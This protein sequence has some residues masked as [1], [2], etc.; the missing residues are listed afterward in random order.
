MNVPQLPQRRLG[1][2][3][4]AI[5]LPVLAL[6]SAVAVN[7]GDSPARISA[8]DLSNVTVHWHGNTPR[9]HVAE[10]GGNS[11]DTATSDEMLIADRPTTGEQVAL[12]INIARADGAAAPRAEVQQNYEEAGRWLHAVSRGQ[13]TVKVEMFPRDVV[14][15]SLP[16]G[17]TDAVNGARECEKFQTVADV[18]WR[19][20]QQEVDTSRLRFVSYVMPCDIVAGGWGQVRGSLTWNWA[21]FSK[22]G[23]LAP[24]EY[25]V[26][27]EL[28]HNLGLWHA[29]TLKCTQDGVPVSFVTPVKDRCAHLEY[30][31]EWSFMGRAW[32]PVMSTIERRQIGWLRAG[33]QT[34]TSE[35]SITLRRD[36]APMLAWLRNAQ[37]DIFAVEHVTARPDGGW[38]C[39]GQCQPTSGSS[40]GV[41]VYYVADTRPRADRSVYAL[42]MT[43]HTP[44]NSDGVLK[45]MQSWTDPTG[46]VT[47]T[48]TN[49]SGDEAT[50]HVRAS[51]SLLPDP[52]TDIQVSPL[53]NLGVANVT[54][55]AP[56]SSH[57]ISHYEV[58]VYEGAEQREIY[59]VG[60]IGSKTQLQVP[61]LTRGTD[62]W[63]SVRA[64]SE[65]GVGHQAAPT[66][67]RWEQP[68]KPK[69]PV[70]PDK[71]CKPRKKCK[72]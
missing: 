51:S 41:M 1:R 35:G 64:V 53:P 11:I 15:A 67:V 19:A 7:T 31:S 20:I 63:V 28:G 40:N 18:A 17:A 38:W 45:A 37:G 21:P 66:A 43:P 44:W 26:A 39:D 58:R 62:Y 46:T 10:S 36:G 61:A 34:T 16:G 25:V 9:Y 68:N 12:V 42:D 55:K 72:K 29:N 60:V 65:L 70:N 69:D 56:A 33:E 6:Y 50:V 23:F 59:L 3:A 8:A 27:H 47:L 22:G 30:G 14:V 52:V 13:L 5:A 54:W 4:N 2:R 48:V 32:A 24:H 49:V 71:P 57:A